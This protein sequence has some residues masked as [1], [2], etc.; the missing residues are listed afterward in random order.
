MFIKHTYLILKNTI[1][2]KAK[3]ITKTIVVNKHNHNDINVSCPTRIIGKKRSMKLLQWSKKEVESL[4]HGIMIH[5]EHEIQLLDNYYNEKFVLANKL[6]IILKNIKNFNIKL[7]KKQ[8]KIQKKYLNNLTL[9]LIKTKWDIENIQKYRFWQTIL[10]NRFLSSLRDIID[11]DLKHIKGKDIINSIHDLFNSYINNGIK[12]NKHIYNISNEVLNNLQFNNIENGMTFVN[13]TINMR[14]IP[15]SNNVILM[16]TKSAFPI[17]NY[18]DDS[19]VIKN[20]LNEL[21]DKVV[22]NYP[23]E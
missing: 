23:N 2:T 6:D 22:N 11:N 8:L 20:I 3:N 12:Y 5:L 19:V 16:K 10:S 18:S 4:T 15:I 7:T 17:V 9:K 14:D 1:T 13:S 21:I